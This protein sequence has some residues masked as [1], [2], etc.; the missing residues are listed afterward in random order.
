MGTDY[1]IR[2]KSGSREAVERKRLAEVFLSWKGCK[3]I[4]SRAFM[5]RG[6]EL[7]MNYENAAGRSPVDLVNRISVHLH[8]ALSDKQREQAMGVMKEIGTA[9]AWD[10]ESLD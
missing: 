2:P 4:G 5:Y 6:A 8:G 1:V 3:P 7:E 10:V 9:L